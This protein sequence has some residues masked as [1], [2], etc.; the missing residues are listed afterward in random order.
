MNKN[1][2]YRERQRSYNQRIIMKDLVQFSKVYVVPLADWHLG[3]QDVALDVIQGYLD[4]IKQHDNAFTILNGDLLNCAGK[5]TSAELFEDLITPDDAYNQVR[6]MLEPIKNKILM[7]T[8]GGHEGEIFRKVGTDFMAR[9]AYDLGDIPYMPDGGMLG[10]RLEKC[11][12]RAVF[13]IYA[14]HG[15]G[16]ARTI[17][18][19]VKKVE[20]LA[21]AVDADC[22]VLSHDHTQSVHRLNKLCPP[23]SRISV[24]RP[25]YMQIARKL[26]ISTGGFIRYSGYIQRMGYIPQ[27]IGTPRILLEIK[28]TQ[29][30]A[31]GYWKDLH[32]SL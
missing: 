31:L 30:G 11:K 4:W 5:E 14:T 23:K 24:T 25:V 7:I 19:K 21:M 29:K 17:G 12:H 18:A 15:W 10:L 2:A 28:Q 27:D 8:R 20:D 22:Y 9:L 1:Q 26:L 32:S 13:F 6:T 3:C 16:G